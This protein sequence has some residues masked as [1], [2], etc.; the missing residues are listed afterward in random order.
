MGLYDLIKR[1]YENK[2]RPLIIVADWDECLQPLKPYAV[3]EYGDWPSGYDFKSFFKD[4]WEVAI[5]EGSPSRENTGI[6]LTGGD[7]NMRKAH[8]K[9]QEMKAKYKNSPEEYAKSLYGSPRRWEVPFT[10]IGEDI[11]KALK[12]GTISELLLISS[13][14]EGVP[15]QI[16]G[17]RAKM[18]RTFGQFPQTKIELTEIRKIRRNIPEEQKKQ[19]QA[20]NWNYYEYVPRRWQRIKEICPD[21]DIL[22][23]DNEGVIKECIDN[24]PADKLYAVPDYA[25]NRHLSSKSNVYL[26]PITVS[27]I[28][29]SDFTVPKNSDNKVDK[30]VSS[31]QANYIPLIISSILSIIIILSFITYYFWKKKSKN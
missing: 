19:S 29:D 22:A 6:E 24:F 25:L 13:Y 16:G 11:L 10:T 28:K 1:E 26:F 9:Y 23:D 15:N 27:D 3:Y 2:G 20:S 5:V 8:A 17:K 30:T 12:E 7:E 31:N 4:F 18:E 14:R 21:F